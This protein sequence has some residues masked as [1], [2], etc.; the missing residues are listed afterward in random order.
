MTDP[1]ASPPDPVTPH[2]HDLSSAVFRFD[3]KLWFEAP[4]YRASDPNDKE[5]TYRRKANDNIY[6]TTGN[7]TNWNRFTTL[8]YY[9]MDD[10]MK[11]DKEWKNID[12]DPTNIYRIIWYNYTY[13]TDRDMD[14][15]PKLKAWATLISYPYL[16]AHDPGA[17]DMNTMRYEFKDLPTNGEEDMEIENGSEWIPVPERGSARSRIKNNDTPQAS[18]T[19]NET[20]ESTAPGFNHPPEEKNKPDTDSNSTNKRS[21]PSK[22]S[23]S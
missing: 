21:S 3:T 4:E 6:R 13:H 22:P 1:T 18:I 14:I 16:L 11:F 9:A 8:A 2:V 10:G 20:G 17:T 15:V 5:I 7:P 19:T 23:H 12:T